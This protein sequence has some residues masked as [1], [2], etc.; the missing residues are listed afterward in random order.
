MRKRQQIG[1][2]GAYWLSKRPNSPFWC[3]T[4]FDPET[5]QTRRE[6]LATQSLGEACERLAHWYAHNV[7]MRRAAPSDVRL[8]SVLERYWLEHGQGRASETS[9]K[10]HI[11]IAIKLIEADTAIS[12][13]GGPAQTAFVAQL[14]RR[15]YAAGYVKRTF[16][17]VK[18]AILWAHRAEIITAVPAFIRG[19]PDGE[20]RERIMS[21][22]ELAR[23]W[24]A[25][26][27]PH[28]QAFIMGMICTV[29]RPAAVLELTRFWCDFER[30]TLDLN[31]QGRE[32]T[33]K[34]RPVLPMANALRPWLASCDG[35]LVEYRGK[36]VRKINAVFRNVRAAAGFDADV[37]PYSIR[38]TMASELAGRGVPELELGAFMGHKMRESRTTGRYVKFRPEYLR[39]AREA[40]DSVVNEMARLAGRA[41]SPQNPVRSTCVLHPDSVGPENPV[42]LGAGDEIRT[43]DPNLGK[44]VAFLVNSMICNDNLRVITRLMGNSPIRVRPVST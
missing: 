13:F 11:K 3:R 32:R 27:Q 29:G 16:A 39:H 28:M 17:T 9:I 26:E 38:H 4:W 24:D 8:L 2:F 12:D 14:H 20:P 30:G 23:L 15:G 25:A 1:R 34:R 43:H 42:N 31:P 41:I 10:T 22:D 35:H 6:S 37:I 40:I 44:A 33:N 7:V 19:L 36:P 5:R 21:I 18:A